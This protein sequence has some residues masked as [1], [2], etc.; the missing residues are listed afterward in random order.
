VNNGGG[1][2]SVLLGKGSDP[3]EYT[4][5]SLRLADVTLADACAAGQNARLDP[6]ETGLLTFSLRNYVANVHDSPITYTGVSA[7]LSS[8]TPGVSVVVGQQGYGPIA[9]LAAVSDATPFKIA[10]DPGFVPGTDV[11]LLLTVHTDQGVTRLPQRLHTGTPG[12]A[13]TLINENFDG[14]AAPALPAGWSSVKQSGS[15]V[16]WITSTTVPGIGA[17]ASQAA[18]HSNTGTANW[19]RLFSPSVTV[20]TPNPGEQFDVALDFDIAVALE[21]EP[22]QQIKAYDGCFLQLH[23]LT[24]GSYAVRSIYASAFA[25][26]FDTG[27]NKGYSHRL[28]KNPISGTPSVDAWSGSTQ[29]QKHVSMRFPGQGMAGHTIQLRFEFIED[30]NGTCTGAGLTGPCGVAVDNVVLQYVPIGSAPCTPVSVPPSGPVAFGL[31]ALWPNPTPGGSLFARFTLP[32]SAGAH[33]GLYDVAGRA[34]R[35]R[36]LSTLG[37]GQHTLEL[38]A[39]VRL[40]PGVYFVRLEQGTWRQARRVVVLR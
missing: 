9:P 30:A 38:A 28:A 27:T 20:P 40:A 18:F 37:P 13:V 23:D 16:P 4:P 39:G 34:I 2:V 3:I 12:T 1:S 31:Q 19:N 26:A 14:V 7:T 35:S 5:A 36:D 22:S 10:L 32:Q 33:L 21:S 24:G 15:T 29:G 11:D 25:D 17:G 8:P 6:G